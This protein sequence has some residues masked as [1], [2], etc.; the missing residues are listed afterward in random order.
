MWQRSASH[1]ERCG[2]FFHCRYSLGR[3]RPGA[4]EVEG[5]TFLGLTGKVY[6]AFAFLGMGGYSQDP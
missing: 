5:I 4:M 6:P 3:E 1:Q 2:P